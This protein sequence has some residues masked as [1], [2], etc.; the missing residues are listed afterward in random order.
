MM[1][2]LRK[3]AK[4]FCSRNLRN[5]GEVVR[6]VLPK[7]YL[8]R[9]QMGRISKISDPY[10]PATKPNV[11]FSVLKTYLAKWLAGDSSR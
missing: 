10:R 8:S 3:R 1:R 7:Y 5:L 11:E 9:S 2:V 4:H 6:R